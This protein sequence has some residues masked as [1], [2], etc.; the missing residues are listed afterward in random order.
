MP[1]G[2]V[3]TGL[4]IGTTKVTTIIAEV[5]DADNVSVIGVGQVPSRGIERGMVVNLE[6]TVQ[7]IVRSVDQAQHMADVRVKAV[8]TSIAG[9]HIRGINSHAAVTVGRT[10]NEISRDDVN[11]VIEHAQTIT[12]PPDLTIIH[13]IPQEFVVDSQQH[14][15]EPIGLAGSR[16][17]GE[18]H[19]VTGA[20]TAVQNVHR[21][22]ERAGLEVADVVLQPLASSMAVLSPDEQ[23]LGVAMLD[24]G[25]GTTD[26]AVFYRKA[27][28]HTAVVGLGGTNVT[29]DIASVLRTAMAEAETLKMK[30]GCALLDLVPEDH[31]ITPP[32]GLGGRQADKLA[33]RFLTE[34]VES[35]MEEIFDFAWRE[36]TRTEYRDLLAGGVVL[37]GGGAMVRGSVELAQRVFGV[38][39]KLGVPTGIGGLSEGVITPM[40]ATGVGLVL[41]GASREAREH[42]QQHVAE[43]GDGESRDSQ[44][45]RLEG[46]RRWFK[47]FLTG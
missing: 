28:R 22:V 16:L 31:D 24:V 15:R 27:I 44:P 4:D 41:Y 19:I 20:A 2:H 37:T 35:R 11:R 6:E 43:I 47:E 9:E 46:V 39:V 12:I 21:A 10:S 38:P 25:G 5:D 33:L 18:V 36:I 8:Y 26:I 14:I 29:N 40:N 30:Y 3:V 1:L 23:E 34:I 32:T 13:V 7:S 45:G 42:P 17:E